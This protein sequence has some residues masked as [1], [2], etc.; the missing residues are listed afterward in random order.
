MTFGSGSALHGQPGGLV[1]RDH[2]V[3]PIKNQ[4]L[5]EV[6]VLRR[7]DAEAPVAGDHRIQRRHPD[8]LPGFQPL[9]G[10]GALAVDPDLAR[11]QQLLQPAEADFGIV[12]A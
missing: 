11:A 8:F 1:D 12:A 3:V 7:S 9:S 2:V 4:R 10:F 6:H 5:N